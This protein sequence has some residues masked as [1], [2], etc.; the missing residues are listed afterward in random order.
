VQQTL[1]ISRSALRYWQ[2]IIY[3]PHTSEM[4]NLA[5]LSGELAKLAISLWEASTGPARPNDKAAR[6]ACLVAVFGHT[7][8]IREEHL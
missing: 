3:V 2:T 4:A 5:N 1:A 8:R 7:L 6:P